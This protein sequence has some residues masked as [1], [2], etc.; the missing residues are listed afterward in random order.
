AFMQAKV[1][2]ARFYAEHILNKAPGIRDS[3]VDGAE[4]VT[5][6]AVDAF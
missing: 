4:S 5:A 2:T 1:V 3:I 6:L